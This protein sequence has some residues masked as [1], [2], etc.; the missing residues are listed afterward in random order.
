MSALSDFVIVAIE[1]RRA[2]TCDAGTPVLKRS[3]L[4]NQKLDRNRILKL[5]EQ[6]KIDFVIRQFSQSDRCDLVDR[7]P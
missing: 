6:L 7:L 3:S 4:R 2:A 5:D 1:Y